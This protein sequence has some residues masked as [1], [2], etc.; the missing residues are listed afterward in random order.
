MNTG[1]IFSMALFILILLLGVLR[2]RFWCRYLC[3]TGAIFSIASLFRLTERKVESTCIECGRC[4]ETCSFGAIAPDYTTRALNCTFC[5]SCG[6][7]CPVH[8]I[9]FTGRWER[10]NLK[11]HKPENVS[12]SRRNF[13]G[14]IA[15]AATAGIAVPRLVSKP[16]MTPVRPPGSVPEEMFLKLCIRCGECFKA[17]PN[18]VLQ[19]I[20]FDQGF[21]ALWTPQ[22]VA[23][24]AGC[25]PTCNN[26]GQVCP[27]GAIRAIPIEEKRAVRIALA[28]VNKRT[29]LPY[30]GRED[31]RMCVDEC[32]AAGYNAIE[33][34]RVLSEFDTDGNP[35][36]GSGFLAPVVI[37]HKCVGCG[38][39]Q[40]RCHSINVKNKK[41]LTESAIQ[42]QA[43][44]GN[45]DRITT[46][47]YLKLQ[48][49]R[50]EKQALD[51]RDQ[52]LGES[53]DD[54]LPDFLK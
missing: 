38:L 14:G 32:T 12:R 44:P 52:G 1:H 17:C 16:V 8:A 31:C 10:V 2:Q 24:W 48:K 36:E 49:D 46:G 20:G 3:P 39:C 50:A 23:D 47:S 29:C 5:Q 51:R 54:Y 19:P 45:E 6:G 15:G 34:E 33:F 25:E 21:D 40:M 26:C 11:P 42:I 9:N 41:L 13:I 53:S 28:A 7:V 18:N 37:A 43:G 4:P 22:V 30:V 27:T 35:I